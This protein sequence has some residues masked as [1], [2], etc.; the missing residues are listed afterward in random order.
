MD[1][2]IANQ[3][4]RRPLHILHVG[5]KNYPPAH[6]G[7][8]K[9][10]YD[11][12]EGAATEAVSHILVERASPLPLENVH[13]L[14]PGLFAQRRQIAALS[15]EYG[16]DAVHL[17]KEPFIPLA[18]LVW[19]SRIPCVLTLHGCAW[20]LKNRWSWPY[21]MAFFILDWT[22]CLLLPEVVFVGRLDWQTFSR[23]FPRKTMRYIPNGVAVPPEGECGPGDKA[24]DAPMVYVGRLSPEKNVINLIHAAES[25]GVGLDLYGPKDERDPRFRTEL[26]QALSRSPFARWRGVLGYDQLYPTLCRYATFVNVSYSEGM[27]VSVLEAAACGLFLV[28]SDIPQHRLLGMPDACYFP[29][30]DIR[31][32]SVSKGRNGLGNRRKVIECYEKRVMVERYL[33]LY[34]HLTTRT[35]Q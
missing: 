24:A 27:P 19:M 35:S 8:E 4:K 2:N 28:L 31:L 22:A 30:G 14:A 7:V 12:V 5:P 16:L 10:V 6:G 33:D 26:E 1:L 11:L 18:L 21:R 29:P 25:A 13:Q 3:N 17:H 34:D 15:K 32:G 9:V 23:M 20:R